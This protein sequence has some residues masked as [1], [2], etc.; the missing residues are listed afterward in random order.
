[1]SPTPDVLLNDVTLFDGTG[2]APAPG[3]R[4]EVTEGRITAVGPAL[5]GDA[6]P[7]TDG[8]VIDLAGATVLP[9][10]I[11]LHLHLCWDGTRNPVAAN[12]RD[13]IELTIVKAVEHARRT[14]MSGMTTVRDVG[15]VEDIAL[16]IAQAI[17]E[18]VFPGPRVIAS[19]QTLIMTGGHDPF[20]GLMVDGA[21]EALKAVRRQVYAGAKVIKLS[22]TGGVYGRTSGE[23]VGQAELTREEIG[24]ICT[25]A[26]R[27]GVKVAA[28]AIGEAGI[29]NAVHGGVDTIEHGHFLTPALADA[30]ARRG[31]ALIPTLFVYRQIASQPGIPAY[32]QEKAKAIVERHRRVV[33]M[34]RDAGVVVG[35][36]TDAGSP[37]TPHP[38][39]I[40][41]LTCLVDAG[42]TPAEAL[43]AATST[44]AEILDLGD[45]IGTIAPGMVADLIAVDGDPTA[46][47]E[48]LRD[49]RLV[50]RDGK[51]VRSEPAA[52][53]PA[54]FQ[55]AGRAAALA[56]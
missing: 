30:M 49:I 48:R 6:V 9:G 42:M 37:E 55:A 51:V 34:A 27:F 54:V 45:E 35:A 33:Q 32:A 2:S 18:G 21:D 11:D 19:G 3:M 12:E 8:R 40:E 25:E 46:D 56:G 1:M 36:G 28:H 50:V 4:V 22:A 20:W 53:G 17:D 47:L 39:M 38:T 31:T 7:R 23:D 29:A 26:H 10:L 44:A 43:A 24:V 5:P 13:G 15:S 41:E 16:P 52:G 14:L